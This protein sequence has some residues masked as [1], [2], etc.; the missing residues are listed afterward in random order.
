MAQ[1][2]CLEI[3]ELRCGPSKAGSVVLEWV[4]DL[5]CGPGIHICERGF[6]IRTPDR[7]TECS[8]PIRAGNRTGD[9]CCQPEEV[10]SPNVLRMIG[11]TPML[12]NRD[13]Q[14]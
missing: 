12:S 6:I 5:W 2:L 8:L 10:D 14:S 11:R 4:T 9:R 7:E 1:D 13:I 3:P